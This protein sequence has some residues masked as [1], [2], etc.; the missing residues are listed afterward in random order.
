MHVHAGIE[1][2]VPL[3]D[4]LAHLAAMG[5]ENLG[6]VDH[7]EMYDP[8]IR[9]RQF[10]DELERRKDDLRYKPVPDGMR[11]F[12]GD[13][14]R[15]QAERRDFRI[16]VGLECLAW[17]LE[18]IPRWAL[19]DIDLLGCCFHDTDHSKEWVYN[20]MPAVEKLSA[21]KAAHDIPTVVLHH[22]LRARLIRYRDRFA[23]TGDSLDTNSL[24]GASAVDESADCLKENGILAEMNGHTCFHYLK[25]FARGQD[26]F[27]DVHAAMASR[28][29][30][31]SI[32]TD[33]HGIEGRANP[34]RAFVDR[35]YPE[36]MD[37]FLTLIRSAGLD[38]EMT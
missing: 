1:L 4:L 26:V 11:D 6:V 21:L 3:D 25:A 12:C 32:G 38:G 31:L 27:F 34:M 24:F 36:R 8:Q 19:D 29:V 22:P 14:R 18:T 37:C 17:N 13:M 15:L 16:A 28:G 30:D 10:T 23:E 33:S 35:L 5:I 7:V 2:T 9:S 20:T